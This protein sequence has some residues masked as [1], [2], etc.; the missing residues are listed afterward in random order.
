MS[1]IIIGAKAVLMLVEAVSSVFRCESGGVT[2]HFRPA[3]TC[4]KVKPLP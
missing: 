1:I 2:N 4:G 3:V